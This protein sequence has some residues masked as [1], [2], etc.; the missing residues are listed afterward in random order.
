M[1]Q[2][3]QTERPRADRPSRMTLAE[4]AANGDRRFREMID[5][6][7]AAIYTT[8]AEGR[9]NHFNPAAV[10]LSGRTPEVG[11][12]CWCVTWKL[13][14]PDGTPLPHEQCPM[15]VALRTGR[16]VGRS[17]IIAERPDGTRV[18]IAAYPMPLLENG[19]VVGGINMLLD[20]TDQKRAE[21]ANARLAAIV[22]SSD[23]AIIS[24]DLTGTITSWNRGAERIFGYTAAEAIGRPVTMLMPPERTDEEAGILERIRRG[25]RVDHYETVRR[26]KDGSLLDIS[27]TVSPVRDAAG[28]IIGASK[29]ARDIT[30]RKQ[31]GQAVHASE[32]RY[33]TLF[34]LGPVAIYTIDTAG[35]IQKF[36]RQ[37]AMLWGREPAVGD[38]DE[39]FCGSFK[40]FRPDGSHMPHEL[41]PMADVV[42]GKLSEVRDGE[43]HIE[44]PDGSRVV[45]VVN[46]RPLKNAEGEIVGAINC[47]YD[48][49]ERK[50]TEEQLRRNAETFA[51]LV[52]QAPFGI[53]VLD[54]SF[55]I[56]QV[57]AGA[58]PAFRN[59]RPLIGRD[60]S[61]ALRIIWPEPLASRVIEI[62]RHTLQTGEPYV[63]PS[64][65]ERRRDVEAVESYEW[66]I[67]RATLPDGQYGVVCYF[68]DATQLREAE[69]AL[70]EADRRKDV[71]LA[72]L[73]HEL[74]N[75]LSAI[76][77]AIQ[78]S[79]MPNL[80]DSD[81]LWVRMTLAR[82]T[83]QLGRLVDDL[84]DVARITRD[85]IQLKREPLLVAD[86]VR[87][88]VE[89]TR[90]LVERAR[91]KLTIALPQEPLW[92]LADPARLQQI[93][94]N[95]LVNAVK[96][97]PDGGQI[98]IRASRE[99][100]QVAIAVKDNG[101]G[102]SPQMQTQVFDLFTQA[103]QGI[104]RAQGGLGIGLTLVRRL[105]ERH[106]GSV[107]VTSDGPHR[108]SEFTVRLP[109]IEPPPAAA[110][111]ESPTGAEPARSHR[112]LIVDDNRDA[113]RTLSLLLKT[114]GHETA[115][116]FD[117]RQALEV[118]AEFRPAVALLDLGLPEINGFDLAVHLKQGDPRIQLIAISGYG[119][120]ADRR[121]SQD[122]GFDRHFVKPVK[123]DE[124]LSA[125]NAVEPQ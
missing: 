32:E 118:A 17:E 104:E 57:S 80:G 96:Y 41:C 100:N 113:G 67:H 117:G 87:R 61:E 10:L 60:F 44:R 13:Y 9:V 26:H 24:K 114:L 69:S 94:S 109:A 47:F 11:S 54:A 110:A 34:D 56:Q 53:Y 38:T 84:L 115:L 125:L 88:S 14:Q 70:R 8:D 89:T 107:S 91:H 121:R 124:L 92:V 22:E 74:R 21:E 81:R 108:G 46:I 43:V 49:T 50:Q 78:L 85:R 98:S 122:A 105:V 4:S 82:Q 20:I 62:F 51:K 63:A 6:L 52:E 68:F 72:M 106:G 42:T 112:I 18:W 86:V 97:T 7:P 71:F 45:V 93:V 1:S 73:G 33:R 35:V 23:D 58:Q 27:L 37:A 65:T 111:R 77:S 83:D 123:I 90:P 103:E 95:L 76:T 99:G 102:L 12:D 101:I 25:E 120:A 40:M 66:Q 79:E 55:R 64:L 16:A 48:I 119:Q 39:R 59:V 19:R 116:A 3:A 15:A 31:A 28:Q 75:P 2:S 5:A 29:V 36:N 30:E